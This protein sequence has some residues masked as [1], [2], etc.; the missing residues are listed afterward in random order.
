LSN[1]NVAMPTASSSTPA[2]IVVAGATGDLGFRIAQDLR[3]RGAT[4]RALVRPGNTKP[5]VASLREQGVGIIEVDFNNATALAQACAGAACVVSALSGLRDVI[6]DA[7]TR[8][9]DAAVAAGVPR[10][11]PSDYSIDFTKL[12]EGSNRNLDLRR[13]F[14]RRLDQAPIRATSILNGMFMDLLTGQAPVVLFKIKRVLYWGSADQPLDFTTIADT[15][16]FTAAAALDL[17]T[18]RYLRVA[19]EVATVRDLQASASAAT[20]QRFR[21]LRAGGLWLLKLMIRVTRRFAPAPGEVFPPWQ[22]MQYLHNMFTGLPK[23]TPLD[24]DRY[25]DIRW[26]SVREVLAARK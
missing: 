4:V 19:G 11:I 12:P 16:A 14:G 2:T 21:R 5:A 15:A 18:P 25:P 17:T 7:Q 10:F 20:G 23:L 9:L 3:K 22:G 24:N 13:E 1:I 8:L 6:V 26:T